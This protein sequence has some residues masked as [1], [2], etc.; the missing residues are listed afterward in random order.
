[1]R[2][3]ARRAKAR[4]LHLDLAAAPGRTDAATTGGVTLLLVRDHDRSAR[5]G[6]RRPRSRSGGGRQYGGCDPLPH[7]TPPSVWAGAPARRL[8]GGHAGRPI[9]SHP[10][11][12]ASLPSDLLWPIS[13][14]VLLPW[15][16]SCQGFVCIRGPT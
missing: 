6:R 9:P 7:L 12:I 1:M 16:T 4:D 3:V 15:R 5:S 13:D 2:G 8:R 11:A 10:L 14:A